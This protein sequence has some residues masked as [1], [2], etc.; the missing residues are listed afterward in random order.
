MLM[1]SRHFKK[2]YFMDFLTTELNENGEEKKNLLRLLPKGYKSEEFDYAQPQIKD[3]GSAKGHVLVTGKLNNISVLDF[4]NMALYREACELVPD[5]H[6]YYTVQTRRGMHVYFLYDESITTSKISK[7]DV[8][9]NGKLVIGQ[10][11]LLK[12]FNGNTFIYTYVGGK[13][14]K[15]PKVLLDWCC[16]VKQITRQRKDFE[17]SIDYNYEATDEECREIL[18]QIAEKHRE[19]FTEYSTWITFT[20]IMKTLNKQELWDEYSE[21]YSKITITNTRT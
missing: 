14:E 7:I 9:T 10:D 5:L 17:T 20:A 6:R 19:Y 2:V 13:I 16:N 3:K 18:D 15:M 8:Q 12:R 1:N 11:T 4:D 21:R